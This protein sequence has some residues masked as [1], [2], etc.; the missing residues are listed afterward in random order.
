MPRVASTPGMILL[1][2]AFAQRCVLLTQTQMLFL[3]PFLIVCLS[4]CKL[5]LRKLL[6]RGGHVVPASQ[7]LAVCQWHLRESSSQKRLPQ[8]CTTL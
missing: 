5:Q 4:E 7:S 6:T 1:A 2:K 3:I 8:G